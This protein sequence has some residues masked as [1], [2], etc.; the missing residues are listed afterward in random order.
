MVVENAEPKK[1]TGA[2][3][4]PTPE[5]KESGENAVARY[6]RET[7]GEMR[8][9]TWPTREEGWRLTWIVM[10]F[11]TVFALFLG[12]LDYLWS[13]VLQEFI[14]FLVGA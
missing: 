2:V 11:T 10:A 5:K 9:V 7:R 12:L 14:R 4:K 8:K 3:K 1:R 6:L 13:T